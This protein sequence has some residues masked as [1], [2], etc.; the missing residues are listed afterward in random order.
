ME[1]EEYRK[2]AISLYEIA[3]EALGHF[4]YERED[5]ITMELSNNLYYE[6]CSCP[7]LEGKKDDN[8]SNAKPL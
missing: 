5:F 3:R 4:G 1:E 8:Q 6:L 7:W 2:L